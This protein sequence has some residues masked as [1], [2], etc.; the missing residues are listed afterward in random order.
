MKINQP[1]IWTKQK[2]NFFH[3]A[4][5]WVILIPKTLLYGLV[6]RSLDLILATMKV[7]T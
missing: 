5:F 7:K 2:N 1:K 3:T 6:F 4:F